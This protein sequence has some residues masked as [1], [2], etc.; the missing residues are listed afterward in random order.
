VTR[1][2]IGIWPSDDVVE[3]L[4]GLPRKNRPGIRWLPPDNW[5]VTLRFLG[6]ADADDVADH[7]DRT[8]IPGAIVRYGPGIDVLKEHTIIVPVHG[9]DELALV[10]AGATGELGTERPRKRFSGHLSLARLKRR[11]RIPDVIGSPFVAEQQVDTIGLV[12]STLRPDG[13]RYETL[14]TWVCG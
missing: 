5:H 11:A 9:V 14:A 8:P 6:D 2:F 4:C 13:A 3:A 7:L 10:V 1:L 12:A